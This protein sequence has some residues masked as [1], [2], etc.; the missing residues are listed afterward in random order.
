M[1]TATQQQQ[2]SYE[3]V[4]A[5]RAQQQKDDLQ[6]MYMQQELNPNRKV[7]AQ[8]NH[9]LYVPSN[10]TM[11]MLLMMKMMMSNQQI[12]RLCFQ[13]AIS[14]TSKRIADHLCTNTLKHSIS[15]SANT[16]QSQKERA[17]QM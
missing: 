1:H 14:V 16:P 2:D 10:K 5:G 8:R 6:K 7:I 13:T 3:Y 11:M 12:R 9:T 4:P 15:L 17:L